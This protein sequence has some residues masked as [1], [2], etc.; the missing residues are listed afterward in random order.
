[1]SEA[2]GFPKIKVNRYVVD[3]CFS[4]VLWLMVD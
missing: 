3:F 1:M 4:C 2:G